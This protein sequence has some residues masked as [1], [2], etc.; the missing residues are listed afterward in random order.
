[1]DQNNKKRKQIVFIS[2]VSII[3]LVALVLGVVAL[4]ISTSLKSGDDYTLRT[5]S[6]RL[7]ALEE[8]QSCPFD[9][10]TLTVKPVVLGEDV[11]GDAPLQI[12]VEASEEVKVKVG[13]FDHDMLALT[14]N[15]AN[16]EYSFSGK[17]I[18]KSGAVS[19]IKVTLEGAGKSYSF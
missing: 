2:T 5:G 16:V 6:Y 8:G 7:E 1:M 13:V 3:L 19:E 4:I 9:T 14:L 18:S 12:G 10:F 11:L 17:L 15:T